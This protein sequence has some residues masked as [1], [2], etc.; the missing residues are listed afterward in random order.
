MLSKEELFL[1][2]KPVNLTGTFFFFKYMKPGNS[3]YY[4]DEARMN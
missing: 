2:D 4:S 1:S 3:L